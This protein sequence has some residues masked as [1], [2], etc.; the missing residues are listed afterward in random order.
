M[1]ILESV[2]ILRVTI[3]VFSPKA[4]DSGFCLFVFHDLRKMSSKHYFLP[5]QCK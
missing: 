4:M 1:T 3:T 5:L 2:S